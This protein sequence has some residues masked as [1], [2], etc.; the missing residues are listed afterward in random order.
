MIEKI[1]LV[2]VFSVTGYDHPRMLP[3]YG[4]LPME[5]MEACNAAIERPFLHDH[6]QHLVDQFEN[7]TDYGVA[8]I[9][10]ATKEKYEKGI[11]E[12]FSY[13]FGDPA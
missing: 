12:E 13:M 5:N 8:C 10:G 4:P 9:D 3:G 7:L 11:R 6:L 1:L 2:I